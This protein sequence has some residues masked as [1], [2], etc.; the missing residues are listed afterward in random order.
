MELMLLCSYRLLSKMA[1]LRDSLGKHLE[2]EFF[3]TQQSLFRKW[4]FGILRNYQ[5]YKMNSEITMPRRGKLLDSLGEN[6][7]I[8]L[9]G[10][11]VGKLEKFKQENNFLYLTGLNIPDAIYFGFKSSKGNVEQLFIQRGIPER[12]VWEGKKMDVAAAA[13]I[14]GIKAVKYLDE[15]EGI[16]GSLCPMIQRIYA[17]IGNME[18]SRPLSYAMF[19]LMPVRERFPQIRIQEVSEI[20]T[21]LRKVKSDWEIQQLQKAIDVTGKGIMDIWETARVGMYEYELEAMLFYR[22]QSSGL[23]HWGFTPIIAAGVNAATLHYDKN[24]CQIEAGQLVLMDVGADNMNYSAD[25]TRCFP[26]SG[27]FN[28]RQKQV[29]SAVLKTNKEIISMIAP[30]VK[31]LDLHQRSREIIGE[32]LV[33]LGLLEDAADVG[34]YYMHGLGHFLGM[35]THDLGGRDAVLEPGNVITVEPGIYIPEEK[36]GVRIED[37]VLVTEEGYCVLSQNIPKEISEIEEILRAR[38]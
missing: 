12:E 26:I 15:F 24:E 10:A 11:S 35:D 33:A 20:I 38:S 36:L 2:P 34:K 8:V 19:R 28:E 30:G 13:E 31:L 32:E 7:A 1:S 18:F 3:W 23:K 29:Y 37:D 14:S 4:T 22:I 27:S 25:I 6:E 9:F 21:P 16:L 17:N 5:E